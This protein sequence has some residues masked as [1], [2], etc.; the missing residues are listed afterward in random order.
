[1]TIRP[2]SQ[3]KDAP[4]S[5]AKDGPPESLAGAHHPLAKPPETGAPG[6]PAT[7]PVS[8]EFQQAREVI[9]DSSGKAKEV[10][11]SPEKLSSGDHTI[12]LSDGR[13]FIMHVPPK[14]G[15]SS[16]PVMF[17]IA[18]SVNSANGFKAASFKGETGMDQYADQHKFIAVY[19]LPKEHLLGVDSKQKSYAWTAPGSGIDA[20]D[21]KAAGYNDVNYIKAIAA[22]LPQLAKVDSSHKNW[23][24][25]GFSQGGIFLNQLVHE[26]P[27][28]FPTVGL[29]GSTVEDGHDYT[30]AAGNAKNTM[31]VNLHGDGV[32]LPAPEDKWSW[33]YTAEVAAKNLLSHLTVDNIGQRLSKWIAERFI[34]PLGAIDSVDQDPRRQEQLYLAQAAASGALSSTTIDLGTP[35]SAN[36][37]DTETVIKGKDPDADSLYIFDLPTAMHSFPG[38]DRGA[39]TNAQTKY[40]EFD[41]SEKFVEIFDAYNEDQAKRAKK[42]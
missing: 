9:T 1:V 25:I 23:G 13:Q 17:V 28:L 2:Q 18:P 24:A 21:R 19:A 35:I 8:S 34:N 31:I 3:E 27:D 6:K 5:H 11:L 4:P 33:Q 37:H 16:L 26:L 22:L 36:Q 15:N 20:E 30:P 41:T 29:V 32:T 7:A 42:E 12:Q 39:R 40:T 38:P 10:P 14:T